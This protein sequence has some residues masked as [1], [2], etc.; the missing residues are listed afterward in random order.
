[1]IKYEGRS[2]EGDVVEVSS[3]KEAAQQLPLEINVGSGVTE[4]RVE[5]LGRQASWISRSAWPGP[6]PSED[7]IC[8]LEQLGEVCTLVDNLMQHTETDLF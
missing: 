6:S 7:S 8:M 2:F 4:L 1:M 3:A 5:A